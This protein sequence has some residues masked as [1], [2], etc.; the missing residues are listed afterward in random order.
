MSDDSSTPAAAPESTPARSIDHATKVSDLTVG[1][2]TAIM[3]T[4]IASQLQQVS[5]AGTSHVNS[6]P[7]GFVNGGGHA[8]F[9]PATRFTAASAARTAGL[10]ASHVNSGPPGFVNG[11][12]HA[13]FDPASRFGTVS[14]LPA[15]N[16][17]ASHVNSGPPGFVNGGGHANFDPSAALGSNVLTRV[18][19]QDG[20]QIAL[21]STGPVNLRVRGML[22]TR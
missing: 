22:I 14:S 1:D 7:P 19:L 20:S 10:A 21:P 16:L 8:N 5:A 6:G 12:G 11:G 4:E 17:A 18:T 13:N 15:A 3:R 9:D 2:L